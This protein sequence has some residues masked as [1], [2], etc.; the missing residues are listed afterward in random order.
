MFMYSLLQIA[1]ILMITSICGCKEKVGLI[2]HHVPESK[3]PAVTAVDDV[4]TESRAQSIDRTT[5]PGLYPFAGRIKAV[6]MCGFDS[7]LLE[8]V[9][10]LNGEPYVFVPA[11]PRWI[12][13]VEILTVDRPAWFLKPN[14]RINI[15][16]HS[17]SI[18]FNDPDIEAHLDTERN[19]AL[20]LE[21][22]DERKT[23]CSV[24]DFAMSAAR[25]RN[26]FDN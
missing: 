24:T 11:D 2:R 6:T 13:V 15:V 22:S 1:V 4:H 17:P 25:S 19:F 10:E 21:Y 26:P 8:G 14:R 7:Q 23:G 20:Q 16:V 5:R 9:I 3:T 18:L 12:I